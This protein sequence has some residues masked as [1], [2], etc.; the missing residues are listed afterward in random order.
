MGMAEMKENDIVKLFAEEYGNSVGEALEKNKKVMAQVMVLYFW[1]GGD[2]DANEA[3]VGESVRDISG[4]TA[5]L[6]ACRDEECT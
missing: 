3:V 6:F 5:E 1:K 4:A 2:V